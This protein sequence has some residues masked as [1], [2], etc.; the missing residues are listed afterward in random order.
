[1]QTADPRKRLEELARQREPLYQEVAHFIVETGRPNIQGIV[2][3]ILAQ[4][5]SRQ[6][7]STSCASPADSLPTAMS[8]ANYSPIQLTVDLGERAYPI[9]IGEGLLEDTG[10]VSE[11]VPGRRIAIVTNTVVA[12]L[13]L[14]KLTRTLE[15]AG[16]QVIAIVLPD[17]EEHKNWSSLMQIFDVL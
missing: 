16:R 17:G 11:L 15:A 2:Q 10:K 9:L 13:Y 7:S 6:S 14:D 8:T 3:S 4:L 1:L 5:E 12:P